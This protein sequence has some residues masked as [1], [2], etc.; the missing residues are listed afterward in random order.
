MPGNI[1]YPIGW[2]YI[3]EYNRIIGEGLMRD[4]GRLREYGV[5]I[6]GTGRVSEIPTAESLQEGVHSIL[7]ELEG[8]DTAMLLSGA[9][10]REQ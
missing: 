1:N 7:K 8:E 4:A 5:R 10:T 3:H 9:A 6:G 2:Q